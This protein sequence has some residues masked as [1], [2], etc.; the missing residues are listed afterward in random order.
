MAWSI[1]RA[2]G[3]EQS[4]TSPV[5]NFRN[6]VPGRLYL[7]VLTRAGATDPIATV[8]DIGGNTWTRITAAPA[9]GSTGR[10]VELWI[11]EPV[12][13]FTSVTATFS[14]ATVV[15]GTLYEITGHRA[16]DVVD[17]VASA[18]HA[19]STAPAAVP[20]TPTETGTLVV[21]AVQAN[22]NTTD[23][24]TPSAGWTTLASNTSGT[25]V[26]YRLDAASGVA[27]SVSWT[28]A[29]GQG[30][31]TAIVAFNQASTPGITVKVWN[32]FAEVDAVIEGVWNGSTV[33]P[34]G[35]V[36]VST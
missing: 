10:R 28:L 19:N 9:S 26:V 4:L 21:A 12:A 23:Q 33:V 30:S 20:V 2:G 36:G 17:A 15:Y 3:P 34:M 32:G 24:I 5:V 31:G 6:G 29:V 16:G 7:Y 8:T 13:A 18:A 14:G 27:T 35:S 25:K 11:C 22:S 1:I